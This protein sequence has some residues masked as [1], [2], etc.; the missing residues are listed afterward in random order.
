MIV[1]N[2][3]FFLHHESPLL[4]T[5]K[6]SIIF[7]NWK[8]N[9]LWS[10]ALRNQYSIEPD[11]HKFLFH[12]LLFSSNYWQQNLV[13]LIPPPAPLQPP[14]SHKILFCS[15]FRKQT[16]FEL[17]HHHTIH[18]RLVPTTLGLEDIHCKIIIHSKI[19]FQKLVKSSELKLTL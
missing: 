5:F 12:K 9:Q 8:L 3:A 14:L 6:I 17:S 18:P 2:Q 7:R 1:N 10:Q 15:N 16:L 19:K 4:H 13:W 11:S